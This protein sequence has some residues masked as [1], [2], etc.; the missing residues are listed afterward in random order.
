[1]KLTWLWKKWCIERSPVVP[2]ETFWR[3][4]YVVHRYLWQIT[5]FQEGLEPH[6]LPGHVFD[7]IEIITDWVDMSLD[8]GW[9]EDAPTQE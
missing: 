2:D 8:E 4:L 1:M 6:R 5:K 3:A 9:F 7:S